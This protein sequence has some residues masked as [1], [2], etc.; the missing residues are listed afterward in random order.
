MDLEIGMAFCSSTSLYRRIPMHDRR[1]SSDIAFVVWAST[2]L[3]GL[4]VAAVALGVVPAENPA[5]FP[6]P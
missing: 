5:I 2:I 4:A 3:I 6:V 1:D